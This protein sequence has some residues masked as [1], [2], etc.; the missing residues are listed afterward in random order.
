MSTPLV[1]YDAN[2]QFIQLTGLQDQANAVQP[3]WVNSATMTATLKDASGASVAGATS[4]T[5]TYQTASNGVYRFPVDP[6]LFNPAVGTY[7]LVID[8]TFS[9]T[10]KFHAEIKT[11]V[12]V[13]AL[14]T[15][16]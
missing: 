3:A 15:E 10:V 2:S 4:M 1:L 9:G 12:Q 5:G 6:A 16:T 7:I 11:K 13:R 14:G 8:G